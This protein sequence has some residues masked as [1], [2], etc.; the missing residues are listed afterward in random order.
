MVGPRAGRGLLT[1]EPYAAPVP[2]PS[3]RARRDVARWAVAW[4]VAYNLLH[5]LGALPEGLG[6]A[7]GGT[8]WTDW[9]DLLTPYTVAGTALAALATSRTDRRGWTAALLGAAV[10]AQG[11]AIHLS[12]NSIGN[13]RGDAAPVH[14]WDE[15]LGHWIQ[16]AGLALLI[17]AVAR[18]VRLTAGPLA[19][20]LALATGLTWTTNALE[21]TTGAGSLVVAAAFA[22]WGWRRRHEGIGV[23]LLVTFGTS[24]VLL[25]SYGLWQ[26]GFPAPSSL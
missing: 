3:A 17:A 14:L 26:T 1:A 10:Y 15:V 12:A 19:L 20:V 4:A 25:A 5:H 11:H 13:V 23:L 21:G 18:A 7:G 24:A 22:A 6:P 9:I 8:R 16:Y 2:A